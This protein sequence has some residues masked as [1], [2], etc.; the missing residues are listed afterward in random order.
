MLLH[1][2]Q[3]AEC[4]RQLALRILIGLDLFGRGLGGIECNLRG[5]G[6]SRDH[7]FERCAFVLGISLD[8]AHQVGDQVGAALVLALDIGHFLLNVLA[9]HN[10]AALLRNAV[11]EKGNKSQNEEPKYSDYAEKSFR[12]IHR[13]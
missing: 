10:H 1:A 9:E 5:T 8:R 2:Q 13:E 11:E 6:T 3:L 12:H 4:L 7:I